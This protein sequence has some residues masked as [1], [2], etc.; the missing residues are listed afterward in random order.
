MTKKLRLQD[1]K[2]SYIAESNPTPTSSVEEL[3]HEISVCYLNHIIEELK[4][5]CGI[6]KVFCV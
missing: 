6:L 3:H 1:V 2:N 4:F 5:H